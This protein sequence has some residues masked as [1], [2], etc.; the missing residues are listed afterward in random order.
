MFVG[1]LCVVN[2]D[3]PISAHQKH[4]GHVVGA[5]LDADDIASS[6][7]KR[8][9]VGK[10][11]RR[12]PLTPASMVWRQTGDV[13][14]ANKLRSRSVRDAHHFCLSTRF[15]RFW[16]IAAI[17]QW[18]INQP[19]L[20]HTHAVERSGVA[21]RMECMRKVEVEHYWHYGSHAGESHT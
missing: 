19:T 15:G 7:C 1:R 10:G 2:S 3:G 20:V 14:L 11:G 4:F 13:D 6:C 16:H 17:G 9:C 5:E 21:I 8:S 12:K 18:T